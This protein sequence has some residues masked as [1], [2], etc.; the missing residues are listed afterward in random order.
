MPNRKLKVG[1]IVQVK[2]TDEVQLAFDRGMVSYNNGELYA[3]IELVNS[4]GIIGTI[5]RDGV[6]NGWHSDNFEW[7]GEGGMDE[8]IRLVNL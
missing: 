5:S 6:T 4:F 3:V 1:D 8:L 7:V 2:F